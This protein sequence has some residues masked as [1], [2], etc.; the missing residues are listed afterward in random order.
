[1]IVMQSARIGPLLLLVALL[2]LLLAMPAA[3]VDFTALAPATTR[4]LG[5][6]HIEATHLMD[7]VFTHPTSGRRTFARLNATVHYHEKWNFVQAADFAAAATGSLKCAAASAAATTVTV[8]ARSEKALTTLVEAVRQD[9]AVLLAAGLRCGGRGV[10]GHVVSAALEQS[11]LTATIVL[12]NGQLTDVFRHAR[13][14]FSTN[15][16]ASKAFTPAEIAELLHRPAAEVSHHREMHA[17]SWF[18]HWLHKAE[19]AFDRVKD[20]V[21]NFGKNIVDDA[22][23]KATELL[24]EVEDTTEALVNLARGTADYDSTW[25]LDSV[26]YGNPDLQSNLL[27]PAPDSTGVATDY[28]GGFAIMVHFALDMDHYHVHNVLATIEGDAT[29]AVAASAAGVVSK[30]F[31]KRLVNYQL[32]P[33]EFEIGPIPVSIRPS[34]TVDLDL[35]VAVKASAQI[36]F[37]ATG[38]LQYGFQYDGSN[39]NK[40][41]D[42]S[43]SFNHQFAQPTAEL[44][45]T[46]SLSPSFMLTID[47]IGGPVAT[48][49]IVGKGELK[50][51]NPLTIT[52]QPS[53]ILVAKFELEVAGWTILGPKTLGPEVYDGTLY[54][55]AT[56]RIPLLDSS[57]ARFHPLEA[58]GLGSSDASN[59]QQVNAPAIGSVFRGTRVNGAMTTAISL[60]LG[61]STGNQVFLLGIVN[62]YTRHETGVIVV[63][64]VMGVHPR[65]QKVFLRPNASAAFVT[66]SSAQIP[67]AA[68]AFEDVELVQPSG[69]GSGGALT[70]RLRQQVGGAALGG[71]DGTFVATNAVYT[72]TDAALRAASLN[73]DAASS[74]DSTSSGSSS[75][76]AINAGS[77]AAGVALLAVVALVVA[78]RTRGKRT[79]ASAASP[80]ALT[81][82]PTAGEREGDVPLIAL[83]A[84]AMA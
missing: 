3:A 35:G 62:S 58:V 16:L 7:R 56:V 54:T 75:R 84:E 31:S 72:S 52:V 39:W 42:H 33:L 14:R 4:R 78:R 83:N 13:V 61:G 53:V 2:A 26:A 8:V 60:Q 36:G 80:P 45:M 1:M 77:A 6:G 47:F 59:N 71:A 10:F 81:M 43:F 50:D 40:I 44:E 64:Y 17:Q 22:K 63:P 34:I 29:L 15:H 46:A 18:H 69:T 68:P 12:R 65:T 51:R 11:T 41:R 37:S 19:D 5:D 25:T 66:A 30:K 20:D 24:K 70:L 67:T 28:F 32:S 57:A 38:S 48:L 82:T 27:T 9:S 49:A 79:T 55:L 21:E 76:V 73:A 74:S 23:S